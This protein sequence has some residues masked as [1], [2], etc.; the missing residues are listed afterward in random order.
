MLVAAARGFAGCEVLA[1]SNW[2]L[3]RDD[4]VGCLV[5]APV[6]RV[7]RVAGLGRL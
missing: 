4:Q 2:V 3:A 6:D 1:F 5:F 7:G